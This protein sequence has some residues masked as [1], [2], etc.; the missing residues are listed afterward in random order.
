M[1]NEVAI[2]LLF[3]LFGWKVAGALRRHRPRHRDRR[4][5]GHRPAEARELR[6]GVG[7]RGRA[8]RRAEPTPAD[9]DVAATGCAPGV[10]A[11]RD[12]VGQG[13]ALRARRHRRRRRNPRLRAAGLH[14]AAHGQERVVGG[15]GGRACS[16]SRCTRTRPASS[17]SSR[18]SSEKGAA[19]G[20]VLAFMM[21]VIA[22][23][24]ARDDHPA[25]GSQADAHRRLRFGRRRRHPG[26]RIPLQL[27]LLKPVRMVPH[28]VLF[29]CVHNAGRSQM[30]AAIFNQLA[31]TAKARA[32][33]AGTKPGTAVHREVR[34][35]MREVGVDLSE[36]RPRLLT[37]DLAR[38]AN[39]LVT[40]GCGEDCPVPPR[41]RTG[42]VGV[43]RSR[44]GGRSRRSG[45]FATTSGAGWRLSSNRGGGGKNRTG[46]G[47]RACG[48]GRS[49]DREVMNA[50][51]RVVALVVSR[52]VPDAL[53]LPGDG[54]RRGARLPAARGRPRASPAF[55]SARPPSR[56][57][58]G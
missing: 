56:S 32:L 31:D 30:A 1:V 53:D 27:R 9:V 34:D 8:G 11:V 5:L 35:A 15:A 47:N 38:T 13:L 24:A 36:A 45:R 55:R 51:T 20:T 49:R 16:A 43:A 14:G 17:R 44:R 10:E 25:Q 12:I 41:R 18:R 23:L 40:M 33:S 3:G 28:T 42:G 6:G 7:L 37:R 2:V 21:S 57:R 22:P 29:A 39:T 54:G 48:P 26:R 58:S 52:P 4:G 19:L 46:E 50:G